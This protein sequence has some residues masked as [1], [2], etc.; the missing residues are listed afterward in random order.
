MKTPTTQT[1]KVNIE[2]LLAKKS[3]ISNAAITAALA[4]LETKKQEEQEEQL[5]EHLE[6][7]S[8]NTANAVEYLRIART[9][10]RIMKKRLEAIAAAELQFHSDA[11]I[12]AYNKAYNEAMKL[13]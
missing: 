6:K 1:A 7:V 10:E 3:Q 4:K 8:N 11:N 12:E 9:Q 2:A 5:L 13:V